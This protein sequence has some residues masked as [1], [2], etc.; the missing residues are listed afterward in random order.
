MEMSSLE[1]TATLPLPRRKAS[2]Q[3]RSCRLLLAA[4]WSRG[5]EGAGGRVCCAPSELEG[6]RRRSGPV[7][8]RGAH[9]GPREVEIAAE[10]WR[11]SCVPP[12]PEE[13]PAARLSHPFP[14]RTSAP[15]RPRQRRLPPR[16]ERAQRVAR[17]FEPPPASLLAHRRAALACCRTA[18]KVTTPR[19]APQ[20]RG[21]G[22]S[23][24]QLAPRRGGR[25][26][27]CHPHSLPHARPL[28]VRRWRRSAAAPPA[29]KSPRCVRNNSSNGLGPSPA[30]STGP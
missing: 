9:G 30:G 15:W 17:W 6:S 21:R 26:R 13:P 16:S 12:W 2:P 7:G 28:C 8:R 18:K 4:R 24:P 5:A 23:P 22:G 29:S 14:S 27:A 3:F 20:R 1:L 19:G 10:R 25:L 11:D